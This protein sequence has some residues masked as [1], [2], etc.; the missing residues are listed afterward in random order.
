MMNIYRVSYQ[1]SE[2]TWSSNIALAENAEAV[3]A[4]YEAKHPL[5]IIIKDGSQ[6]DVDAANRKGMPVVTIEAPKTE[7][8]QEA[9]Q[10]AEKTAEKEETAMTININQELEGIEVIFTQKPEAATLDALKAAGFR[11]HRAKKLWY[12]KNTESRMALVQSL[13][14]GQQ[15][16]PKAAQVINLDGLGEKRPNLYGAELAKAIREDLKRRGVSGVT[17]RAR[18]VT[19]DTGITVTIK[20]TAEDFASLEEARARFGF[21]DFYCQVA[22]HGAFTG[23]R[24]IYSGEFDRMTEEQQRTE[25]DSFMLYH[26][27]NAP[28]INERHLIDRRADYYTITTD[29]YNKVVAVFLIANQWNWDHSDSMTDYFDIGYFLDLEVKAPE[30][31]T[32][33][34]EMTEAERRAYA[35]ELEAK[36]AEEAARLA[37]F[38]RQQEESRRQYEEYEQ[39]RQEA[40]ELIADN[41]TVEDLPQPV[42]MESLA[43][44]IGKESTLSELNESIAEYNRRTDAV[45]TRRV[46]FAT[47]E[48]FEAFAG[49]LL[50]DFDWLAG[51][52][53]TGTDDARMEGVELYQLNEDQRASVKWYACDC[54]AVYVGDSLEL[55]CN[56]E[57]YSYSRYTYKPTES[58][59]IMSPEAVEDQRAASE[60]LP[61][62]YF[63]AP[64]EEQAQRLEIGQDVTIYQCD[65]WI[66]NSITA[67]AGTVA[68]I[69]PG[70]Y[71]QYNGVY[72]T[73]ATG[74]GSKDVFLRDGRG[75]LIYEGIRG[76]LPASVTREQ[77][78][79]NMYK[80]LNY[81]ELF[82][83]VLE[84]YGAQGVRPLV[85]TIQR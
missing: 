60:D 78:S 72:I 46:T 14:D 21:C 67:G 26:L 83:R 81:D 47:R 63:P 53:G 58:T 15:I 59:R 23:S 65:G 4:Y 74:R 40:R 55:V 44:G 79:P 33:R 17:V 45:I 31:Y 73:L 22:R 71:A 43:A 12:A 20:A 3:R 77:I 85:D 75:C 7:E 2:Y 1:V 76:P 30:G 54:I 35:E 64:V 27:Q 84:Y 38:E 24:W 16:A 29:F 80:L 9:A 41:I 10:E 6:Y 57:G 70:K 18:K 19:H 37:E 5:D 13:A 56:P 52:G 69:R 49:L 66:L 25:Y 39:K 32:P 8:P 42:Y 28:Q 50:D 68:A 48:A 51:K 11:W 36:E 34:E 61:P 82:P 62:F